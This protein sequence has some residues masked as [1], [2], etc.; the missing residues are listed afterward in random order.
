MILRFIFSIGLFGSIV[1]SGC[2]SVTIAPELEYVSIVHDG[3]VLRIA[4]L[5]SNMI[6][7]WHQEGG[8]DLYRMDL[9]QKDTLMIL[10]NFRNTMIPD[11][12]AF[13]PTIATPVIKTSDDWEWK[14]YDEAGNDI[15]ADAMLLYHYKNGSYDN[16][17]LFISR[18]SSTVGRYNSFKAQPDSLLWAKI[19]KIIWSISH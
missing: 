14:Y 9:R 17:T 7:A 11:S 3:D 15:L 5:K 4:S 6:I 2:S 19:C 12:N 10:M 8:H 13:I 1:L 16:D 18:W